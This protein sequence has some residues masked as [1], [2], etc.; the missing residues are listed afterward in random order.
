MSDPNPSPLVRQQLVVSHIR[1]MILTG[2]LS[3][4][5]R[6]LEI[7]LSERLEVS[8]TPIREALITLA[9]DGLVEYRPNRGYVVRSF[10]LQ[11]VLDANK[12]RAVLESLACR[13]AAEKGVSASMRAAILGCLDDGDR[14]LDVEKLKNS[15][16]VPLREVNDKF[17]NLII[18]IA[19]NEVLTQTLSIATSIPYA[20]TRVVHWY[21]NKDRE[22]L[23][24][25]K[26]FHS[27]H[28]AIFRAICS[29]DGSLAE[30]LMGGHIGYAADQIRQN[31]TFGEDRP[32]L[33]SQ[34]L[35]SMR[36]AS[37]NGSGK[38][39]TGKSQGSM[40]GK[41]RAAIASARR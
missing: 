2:T 37:G 3:G 10:T 14:M 9:E 4:G 19:G 8:R 5:D 29:G 33:A 12:V 39:K 24:H 1:E 34:A 18:Q 32:K 40:P 17:H 35:Q 16:R 36:P 22:G 6:L 26:T 28:H 30:S 11:Y 13:L 15:S 38:S 27:Q 20:S 31:V 41:R 7:D 25:L 23:F 21:K